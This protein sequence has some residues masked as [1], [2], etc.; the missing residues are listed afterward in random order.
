M[1]RARTVLVA[2]ATGLVGREILRSLSTDDSV[3]AVHCLVRRPVA[4]S[5]PAHPKVTFHTVD[6]TALPALPAAD[7]VYIALGTTIRDAGSEAAFRAVDLDAVAA[8]AVAARAAGASRCGLVTAMGAD[9]GSRIFYSRVKG[10]AE[11]AVRAAGFEQLVVAR[12]SMLIVEGSRTALGQRERAGEKLVT[13]LM[14]LAAPLIPA[15]YRAVSPVDVA[16]KLLAT[17]PV[18][19]NGFTVLLS[20]DLQPRS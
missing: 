4:P 8:T 15:N 2:G 12:P 11:A 3:A 7:E 19:V 1:A 14:R 13:P 10:E 17:V 20:G 9:T 16:R 6:F 5:P 18:V